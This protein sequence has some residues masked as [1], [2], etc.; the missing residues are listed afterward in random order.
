MQ[1]SIF[2]VLYKVSKQHLKYINLKLENLNSIILTGGIAK[3]L[4]NKEVETIVSFFY[5]KILNFK[6]SPKV[7]IDKN[8]LIWTLGIS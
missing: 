5:K 6:T 1:L 2:L 3:V 8:Y 7:V 4:S